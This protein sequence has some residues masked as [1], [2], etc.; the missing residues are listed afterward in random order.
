MLG[1][2]LSDS[3]RST[4]E[5]RVGKPF[6]LHLN[7]ELLHPSAAAPHRRTRN[8]SRSKPRTYHATL[9]SA[10][11]FNIMTIYVEKATRPT[12]RSR[13][14]TRRAPHHLSPRILGRLRLSRALSRLRS[15]RFCGSR[16]HDG[17]N[18]GRNLDSASI[19]GSLDS[20]GG[21]AHGSDVGLGI[22][23]YPLSKAKAC[24]R[25]AKSVHSG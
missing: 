7:Q 11:R 5:Y 10:C 15:A 3:P 12:V 21:S 22:F 2:N 20:F 25:P 14:H 17:G 4:F 19:S 23:A 9:W 8:W 13:Q 6:W 16:R 1:I 18:R 24:S